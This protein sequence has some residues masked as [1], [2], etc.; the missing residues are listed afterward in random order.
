MAGPTGAEGDPMRVGIYSRKSTSQE[1]AS[2][3]AKSVTRQI[4]LARAFI[5]RQDGW[6]AAEEHVYVDDAVSGGEFDVTK[7]Q[8]LAALLQAAKST[9]RPFDVLVI[10]NQSRLARRLRYAVDIV[11]DLA[12]AGVRIFNYQTGL[13]RKMDSAADRFM[14]GVDGFQDEAYREAC[15]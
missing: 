9:P 11:H 14:V 4:E 5:E 3:E 13:E 15:Q 1:K 12:D 8:G 10:M 2:H 7:R 6:T